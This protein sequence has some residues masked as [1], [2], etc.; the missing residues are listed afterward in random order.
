MIERSNNATP[1]GHSGRLGY[2][3]STD[4]I[5]FHHSELMKFVGG[6]HRC[7]FS[8]HLYF[9]RFVGSWTTKLHYLQHKSR[10]KNCFYR[11]E[12]AKYFNIKCGKCTGDNLWPKVEYSTSIHYFIVGHFAEMVIRRSLNLHFLVRAKFHDEC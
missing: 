12:R 7:E 3:F 4:V 9:T 5:H 2:I 11:C 10:L 1:S 6:I 8:G